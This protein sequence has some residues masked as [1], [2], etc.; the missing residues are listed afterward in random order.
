M[1][2]D[3]SNFMFAKQGPYTTSLDPIT[4]NW[5]RNWLNQ[6]HFNL[7]ISHAIPF[8]PYQSNPDYDMRGFYKAMMLGDRG[9]VRSE[10]NKHYPDTYKTPLH[11][12]F[13]NE[14]KY[15]TKDAPH[16]EGDELRY[17]Y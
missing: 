12:S 11:E 13:S 7:G 5:F 15:A 8:D 2:G 9:A 4:E 1:A 17:K 3:Y 16:W 6:S 10:T 14:S